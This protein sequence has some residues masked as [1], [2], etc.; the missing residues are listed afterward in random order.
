MFEYCL[1]LADVLNGGDGDIGLPYWPWNEEIPVEKGVI[2]K[3]LREPKYSGV[4]KRFLHKETE[5]I[6]FPDSGKFD[7]NSD[8]EILWRF[9]QGSEYDPTVTSSLAYQAN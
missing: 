7:R 9:Y 6:W 3:F 2:P 4:P 5:Q 8:E 1:R